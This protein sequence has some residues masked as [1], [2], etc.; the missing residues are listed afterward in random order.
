M[1]YKISETIG[2]VIDFLVNAKII[3]IPVIA[4]YVLAIG[5]V[6]ACTSYIIVGFPLSVVEVITKKKMSSN[7]QD[8]I[9]FRVAVILF[10][11]FSLRLITEKYG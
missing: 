1:S 7:T 2:A 3:H 9:I 5:F 11:I 4:M 6:A 10:V 8:T